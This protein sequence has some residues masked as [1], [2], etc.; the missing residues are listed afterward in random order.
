MALQIL[1]H[2]IIYDMFAQSGGSSFQIVVLR[3][4]D[5]M[6][7]CND[8]NTSLEYNRTNLCRT[9]NNYISLLG[10]EEKKNL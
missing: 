9:G 7:Q 6:R 2:D 3:A 10:W 5:Y 4:S 8:L 1:S